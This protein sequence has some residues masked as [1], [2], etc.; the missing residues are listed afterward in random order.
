MYAF[1]NSKKSA[2]HTGMARNYILE[3][4]R[5][6]YTII[7]QQNEIL[8]SLP[9]PIQQE[10]NFTNLQRFGRQRASKNI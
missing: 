9:K 4:N 5:K 7:T 8:N 6:A 1:Q 3:L 2:T 10:E